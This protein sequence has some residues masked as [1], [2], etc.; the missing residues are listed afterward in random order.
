[1]SRSHYTGQGFG[2]FKTPFYQEYKPKY[3]HEYSRVEIIFKG[4]VHVSRLCSCVD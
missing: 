2:A 1:M 3:I 4:K